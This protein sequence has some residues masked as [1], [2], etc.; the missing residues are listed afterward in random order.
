DLLPRDEPHAVELQIDTR[1]SLS[2]FESLEKLKRLEL[3]MLSFGHAPVAVEISM[4]DLPETDPWAMRAMEIELEA[5]PL[6]AQCKR[7]KELTA[8]CDR[9]FETITM[10]PALECDC[11][12]ILRVNVNTG[13]LS[14]HREVLIS[15]HRLRHLEVTVASPTDIE[16]LEG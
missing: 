12:E 6:A 3:N 4:V 13:S 5:T 10:K 9:D 16:F 2:D 1:P 14:D 15:L 11:L 8:Y 7:L